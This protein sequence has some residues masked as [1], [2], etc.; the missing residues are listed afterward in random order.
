MGCAVVNVL[1]NCDVVV[2]FDLDNRA[3]CD[4]VFM[5]LFQKPTNQPDEKPR[6]H[7]CDFTVE[8]P[9]CSRENVRDWRIIEKV[10]PLFFFR[11]SEHVT[12]MT[13]GLC[14]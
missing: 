5:R 9:K 1:V 2:N 13:F 7:R 8:P 12:V 6:T 3:M 10:G 4:I 14:V 11:I